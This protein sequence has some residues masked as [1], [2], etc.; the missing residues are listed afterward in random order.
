MLAQKD[1]PQLTMRRNLLFL[2]AINVG[3][4]I[5]NSE[6]SPI[7][8]LYLVSLGATVVDISLV[9]SIANLVD[10]FLRSFTG[11]A[12]DVYGRRGFIV[13]SS[14]LGTVALFLYTV[15]RSWAHMIPLAALYMASFSLFMPARTALIAD[16]CPPE[17]RT[18]IYSAINVSWPIGSVL[19][20]V[21]GGILAE[22]Y[23]WTHSFYAASAIT[24]ITILPGLM[25]RER[26]TAKTKLGLN[27]RSLRAALPFFVF[28]YLMGFGIGS[29]STIIPLYVQR[30]FNATPTDVGFFFSIGSGAAMFIAQLPAAWFPA[31][32][33]RRKTLILCLSILPLM[34]LLWPFASDYTTL[35]LIYMAINGFWSMSWPSSLSLLMDAAEEDQRGV[36]TGFAQTSLMFGFTAGPLLGGILWEGVGPAAPFYASM[37]VLATTLPIVPRL[38]SSKK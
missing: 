7:W 26:E 14:V 37:A 18:R 4:S 19:G 3:V 24:A 34:F 6:I 12:S 25:L 28:N 2:F 30:L 17:R 11:M 35:L 15:P 20:P 9:A 33:G 8:P 38:R 10:T 27:V 1:S 21:I 32:Y 29:T 16:W 36:L 13:M 31:K 22:R 23:G 5:V